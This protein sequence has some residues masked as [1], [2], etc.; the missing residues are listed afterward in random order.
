M[1][2]ASCVIESHCGIV[3]WW[4]ARDPG[5]ASSRIHVERRVSLLDGLSKKHIP[6]EEEAIGKVTECGEWYRSRSAA[7]CEVEE[8]R[9]MT[10]MQSKKN[11]NG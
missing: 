11:C 1:L 4:A 3:E 7:Q 6:K 9:P 8:L 10:K 2:R 5:A